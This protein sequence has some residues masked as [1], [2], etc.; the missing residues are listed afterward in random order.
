MINIPC[1]MS[2][3]Q[4]LLLLLAAF[5]TG[6]RPSGRPAVDP[7]AFMLIQGE[8]MGTYY[9]VTYADPERRDFKGSLD[10]LLAAIN[11]EVSTYIPTSTI[12][13]FNQAA[14]DF[15]LEG[16]Q[17]HFTANFIRSREIHALTDGAFDPTV[18]PLVNYWGFGYTPKK[19]VTR[20]DSL[21]VDSLLTL[22]GL[23]A[24]TGLESPAHRTLSKPLPGIQLDFSAI[25][26]GYAV[27]VV[28]Q[29]LL[30][31]GIKDVLVDIGGEARG[32]GRSP[33]GDA[34]TLGVNMP[35]ES[36]SLKAMYTAIHLSGK[37]LATSGNYRN[38][39]HVDGR[40]YSHTINPAT[41]FPER[42][43]L[44]SVSVVAPD[45]MTADALATACMVKGL[46]GARDLLLNLPDAE[47]LLIFGTSGGEMASWTSPG[48]DTL[49]VPLR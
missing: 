18:M 33:R 44:L 34:W 6:C 38:L 28:G 8:T 42:N 21:M 5:L 13:R 32:W 36:A 43:A 48:M 47:G 19:P 26:K 24:V 4:C 9:K 20:V 29:F 46:D 2:G 3:R 22:V 39:Y 27:D 10:S 35:E 31:Q 1:I 25:A 12:S 23:A 17:P 14:E 45:A 16:E 11:A 37:G 49:L 30:A 40:T 7:E 41:G 15:T